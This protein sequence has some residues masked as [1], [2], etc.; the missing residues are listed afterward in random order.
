MLAAKAA[1]AS[2]LRRTRV[3]RHFADRNGPGALR[4]PLC[5]SAV[6][7]PPGR[8]L[9]SLSRL[10]VL[11]TLVLMS[12]ACAPDKTLPDDVRV[13][14]DPGSSCPEGFVCNKAGRC[15][16]TG[17]LD[18][19][20]PT[21]V[22][23]VSVGPLVGGLESNLAV[24]F[25]VSEAMAREPVVTVDLGTRQAAL[26]LRSVEGHRYEYGYETTGGE[27]E[28]QRQL[29]ILLVDRSGNEGHDRS[30]SLGFDF[31]PPRV[32][33]HRL[34]TGWLK[35][36]TVA[37]L[38]FEASEELGRDPE[39][40][41][42]D[43]RLWSL[44]AREGEVFTYLYEADA[45]QDV[46]GLARVLVVVEDDAQNRSQPI[47]LGQVHFDFEPPGLNSAQILPAHV[48]LGGSWLLELVADESLAEPPR[49]F[50]HEGPGP[51]E[52]GEPTQQGQTYHWTREVA[53]GEDAGEYGF[54]VE[55][56]D[57]AGNTSTRTL[58]AR[59][60]IDKSPPR[61]IQD[62]WSVGPAR[63][64]RAGDS[65]AVEVSVSEELAGPPAL[66][67]GATRVAAEPLQDELRYGYTWRV[68]GPEGEDAVASLVIEMEDLAGNRTSDGSTLGQVVLDLSA[69]I[70]VPSVEPSPAGALD[71][72]RLALDCSETLGDGSPELQV[73]RLPD[74]AWGAF[75][76]ASRSGLSYVF[77]RAVAE[78]LTTGR[79]GFRTR[80]VDL[81]GNRTPAIPDAWESLGVELLVDDEGPWILDA[82][83]QPEDPWTS[84]GG[85][86]KAGDTLVVAFTVNEDLPQ[87]P[88]VLLRGRSL[89]APEEVV[90]RRYTYEHGVQ[91]TPEDSGVFG[92]AVELVDGAGNRTSD[93][94]TLGQVTLDFTP[95]RVVAAR[96]SAAAYGASDRVVYTVDVDESLMEDEAQSSAG[97]PLLR[98]QR[99]GELVGDVLG[100]AERVSAT[101]FVYA[102]EAAEL[103]EGS[104]EVTIGIVDRAGNPAL[105][106][107]GQ[108]FAVDRV[109][110]AYVQ[111]LTDDLP[112]A[113]LIF[114]IEDPADLEANDLTFHF[115]MEE[116][117]TPVG[118]A[119][120]ACLAQCPL[121]LLGGEVVGDVQRAPV[122]DS[123]EDGRWGFRYSYRVRQEDWGPLERDL[124]VA[125]RWADG[126]GNTTETL[127]VREDPGT[128]GGE[129]VVV[130]FDFKRPWALGCVLLPSTPNASSTLSYSVSSSEFLPAPPALD[131]DSLVEGLFDEETLVGPGPGDE[132]YD[133]YV[134]TWAQS[135]QG[136]SS[137]LFDIETTLVDAAGNESDGPVCSK[138]ALL[139]TLPPRLASVDLDA[140]AVWEVPG[141]GS[142]WI[143]GSGQTVH[144]TAVFEEAVGLS[145]NGPVIRLMAPAPLDF[146]PAWVDIDGTPGPGDPLGCLERPATPGVW[147][148]AAEL[149][150]DEVA[151]V[152]AEGEWPVQL[153]VADAHGNM[154][155]V[156]DILTGARLRT[157]FTA[158]T[159]ACVLNLPL[160]NQDDTVE[161]SAS[162]SEPL[163]APPTLRA[164]VV[165]P[166]EL[167][168]SS[169]SFE[170][171]PGI[172][173][174]AARPSTAFVLPSDTVGPDVTW[175]YTVVARD[176]AGNESEEACRGDGRI[177]RH[178]IIVS[179][180]P[181]QEGQSMP[182]V[183][184]TFE[185]LATGT[186]A[187]DGS[188]VTIRFVLS[189]APPVD[190]IS[191]VL[192]PLDLEGRE[193]VVRIVSEAEG[194]GTQYE[195]RYVV[196]QAT[197]STGPTPVWLTVSDE[198]GNRTV[199]SLA[200]LLLDYA[201]P[202]LAGTALFSRCD[203]RQSAQVAPNALWVGAAAPCPD[204]QGWPVE[205]AFSVGELLGPTPT[206]T[207][208]GLPLAHLPDR[209][210]DTYF[211]F[212]LTPSG[213]ERQTDSADPAAV[214]TD[215][216]LHARDPA[217]N[218]SD[219]SLGSLR[220]DYDSP[221]A[222]RDQDQR[223]V[224]LFRAPWGCDG[225]SGAPYTEFATCP[226]P[227]EGPVAI[228]TP[229][230]PSLGCT[231]LSSPVFEPESTVSV[232]RAER[233]ADGRW[234]C[235]ADDRP[236][237]GLLA[238][239]RLSPSL[240]RTPLQVPGDWQAVC[241]GQQDPAG[242]RSPR[243]LVEN[244]AWVATLGGKER[245]SES[246]N[247]HRFQDRPWFRSVLQQHG[248]VEA[249]ASDGLAHRSEGVAHTVE[250]NGTWRL[251]D[252]AAP[253]AVWTP[254]LAYDSIR[255]ITVMFG[256]DQDGGAT[257]EWDGL[258]WR[259]RTPLDPEGDGNPPGREVHAMAFDSRRGVVVLFGGN[260]GPDWQY[261]DT[262]EWDGSSWAHRTPADPEGDGDPV[263]RSQHAMGF[264]SEN[265]VVVLFGGS[266]Y[267]PDRLLEDTWEWDGVSWRRLVY[268]D[269]SGDGEPGAMWPTPSMFFDRATKELRLQ[270]QTGQ[271]R[272]VGQDWR[273][274][275]PE[276]FADASIA[277]TG[278][279]DSVG[280]H[281]DGS[282]D[283]VCDAARS[284]VVRVRSRGVV[285]EWDG[286]DW[287]PKTASRAL[288]GG[289][290]SSTLAAQ[291][292][293]SIVYD[294][295]LGVVR[296]LSHGL[297][298]GYQG[299][300]DQTAA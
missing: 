78:G 239:L 109:A 5:F 257:W 276:A 26:Q 277:C 96:P 35:H 107:P 33:T 108:G 170:R 253:S 49:A 114:G 265:G 283:C 163:A 249:G 105:G 54:T 191:L 287:T 79:Y 171:T 167:A 149:Q 72:V 247:P 46:P 212:G 250:G 206:V 139:D 48:R 146:D 160:A 124:D 100:V 197:H 148:C 81:A 88:L 128:P 180:T 216:L 135:A 208:D 291:A 68:Q 248:V 62:T 77:Q 154:L 182:Y 57:Q 31:S 37:R 165:E 110:P 195:Y 202:R 246:G 256:R 144:I 70:C 270:H 91:G 32:L 134:F 179:P 76:E 30:A 121:V 294:A 228:P 143:V 223:S 111:G 17:A 241:V 53:A 264:D 211:V 51:L 41:F 12:H 145:G 131:V 217:G 7:R 209:S 269:P 99:V 232:F 203:S 39:L 67:V 45:T 158:P 295:Q 267:F 87:P 65:L 22:G 138:G 42:E 186:H 289:D 172:D 200:T 85:L 18:R 159:A 215:V 136:L 220:F 188:E 262:W 127:L 10:P 73:R 103:P 123:P 97:V 261:G 198:A 71:R 174:R 252:R 101:R 133:G 225:C 150:L 95:P 1:K 132:D 255:G 297:A 298:E 140:P 234:M 90:G 6:S 176:L 93:H 299:E 279:P 153:E 58:E 271:W 83:G 4:R 168:G 164:V 28:G 238:S 11:L 274:V 15:E 204:G 193:D 141:G 38:V 156:E 272:L 125:I 300:F 9:S 137:G 117:G 258:E 89:G 266:A 16:A 205:V 21:V 185:G 192:P 236:D 199:Q 282:E 221:T 290:D 235:G 242:N 151:D 175:A 237:S 116:R 61:V 181:D 240:P 286:N 214:G 115:V 56:R 74:G 142:V 122:L 284:V 60:E 231:A 219:V 213:N 263:A 243:A 119:P 260:S 69:P 155:R 275:E 161:V 63:R 224:E 113:G 75:A 102:V 44:E 92:L 112:S 196:H 157:D 106:L 98:V 178:P 118:V 285:D 273:R 126:A 120:D 194:G 187:R 233:A 189:D 251:R 36:E 169:L 24:S 129:P 23:G 84:Q 281:V 259:S 268:D 177:D 218:S 152:E 184:A 8:P 162:F 201:A 293:H 296:V 66:F 80:L 280:L 3:L 40:S 130:R 166:E 222:L 27:P 43:G 20:A 147:H 207:V 86:F 183:S 245:G 94:A 288:G 226:L 19:D 50:S 104:Y 173:P 52:L 2:R 14:C 25:A 34:D 210:G 64:L 59:L 230:T 55:L 47:E 244:V 82:P 190:K 13:A 292:W 29:T 278:G 227:G 229:R 254:R